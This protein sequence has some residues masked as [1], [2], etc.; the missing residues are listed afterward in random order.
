MRCIILLLFLMISHLVFSQ[1]ITYW[2]QNEKI[3]TKK[4]AVFYTIQTKNADKT[5]KIERYH[6]NGELSFEGNALKKDLKGRIGVH[7]HY[8]K[9]GVI[10]KKTLY[11]DNKVVWTKSYFTT[12][13]LKRESV[14][15]SGVLQSVHDY[16]VGGNLK[17]EVLYSGPER[18]RKIQ[19]KSY[20]LNGQLKRDDEYYDFVDKE[21]GRSYKLVKAM[22]LSENGE[23]LAHIPF[24]RMPQFPG[25]TPML[26]DYI[27]KCVKYPLSAQ[28][29]KKQGRVFV[30]FVIAKDGRV[31]NARLV[32]SVDYLLDQEALRVVRNM[33]SWEPGIQYGEYVRMPY[34]IPID[35]ML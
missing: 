3:T 31:E 11:K 9:T 18:E 23:E 15:K 16:Y 25:G 2:D 4:K 17:N 8:Y 19:V 14:Y 30:K 1:K 28:K 6:I 33:P 26:R 21:Q 5:W 24:F 27:A 20:Y 34:V 22:V 12:S 29:Y 35:F 13:D 32:K 7:T 10:S